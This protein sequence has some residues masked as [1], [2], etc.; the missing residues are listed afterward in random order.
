MNDKKTHGGKR[1]GAGRKP[2][3]SFDDVIRIGQACEVH[4][5]AVAHA[6][7]EKRTNALISNEVIELKTSYQKA[8]KILEEN[9]EARVSNNAIERNAGHPKA[10]TI[11][12]GKMQEWL[13]D[14]NGGIQHMLDVS[15][16]IV[17]LNEM[18]GTAQPNNRVF[19]IACKAPKGTRSRIIKIVAE[20]YGLQT[21]Q[22]DNLWQRYRRF[23][24]EP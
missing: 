23:E 11:L 15:E 6:E 7:F 5:R 16:E 19:Q 9:K 1:K 8:L 24:R 4:F 20:E 21:T 2:N 12:I 3:W 17:S 14:E 13:K 10:Q 18:T 22:V